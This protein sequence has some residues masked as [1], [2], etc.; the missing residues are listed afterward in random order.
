MTLRLVNKNLASRNP[1]FVTLDFLKVLC[2]FFSWL[3]LW[4]FSE[5]LKQEGVSSLFHEHADLFPVTYLNIFLFSISDKTVKSI[6]NFLAFLGKISQINEQ[7]S[8]FFRKCL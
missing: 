8:C 1:W 5:L 6:I 3:S 4:V 2:A 7:F